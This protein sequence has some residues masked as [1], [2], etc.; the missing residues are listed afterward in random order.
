MKRTRTF[1]CELE[2]VGAARRFVTGAL[3]DAP[4]DVVDSVELMVSELATNC[5][6]HAK[7]AFELELSRMGR[8][9]RVEVTDRGS[10]TPAMR[11]PGPDDPTGRGL[12]I[13][14]MLAKTW[15]VEHRA[16]AGNSVWFTLAAPPAEPSP[17][18]AS[19]STQ[20][21]LRVTQPVVRC[22]PSRSR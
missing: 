15:G 7:T 11:S 1:G 2:S 17:S 9:V 20:A 4:A 21:G 13:V 8:E 19:S 10:G 18:R 6:R 22:A 3:T 14:N 5:I 16:A 12:Q